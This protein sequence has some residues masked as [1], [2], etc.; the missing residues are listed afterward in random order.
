MH[1]IK[2]HKGAVQ[3]AGAHRR[4]TG[5]GSGAVGLC[6]EMHVGAEQAQGVVQ[7]PGV[8]G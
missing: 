8:H 5:T 7:S 2:R 3:S 4:S 6:A 1:V